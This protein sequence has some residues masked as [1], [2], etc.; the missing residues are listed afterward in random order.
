VAVARKLQD[1]RGLAGRLGNLGN[2][3]LELKEHA[4]ALKCFHEAAAI[5]QDLGEKND[6]ALRLG[7][8]G[9]IYSELGCVAS[10][11]FEANMCFD[12]A[13]DAYGR[14]L[15]LAQELGDQHAEAE[16]MSS[17]GN[18]YGNLRRYDEAIQHFEISVALF[19]QLGLTDRLPH[20]QRHIDL[21][22]AMRDG[23]A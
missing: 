16:L 13:L 19:T 23:Q 9:N 12:L 15:A 10:S 6:A 8:I 17:I 21:A 4:E 14:T 22:S 3:Y 20:L 18:V 2:T 11:D 5:Y 1:L 7:I